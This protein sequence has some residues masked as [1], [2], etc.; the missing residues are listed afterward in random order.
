MVL[1]TTYGFFHFFKSNNNN[2]VSYCIITP[3]KDKN[4]L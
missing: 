3:K 1:G 4:K 2:K